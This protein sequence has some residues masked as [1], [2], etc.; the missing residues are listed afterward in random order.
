MHD[1]H[2][3][4][5]TK[6]EWLKGVQSLGLLV[7]TAQGPPTAA[8]ITALFDQIDDD[9]NGFLDLREATAALKT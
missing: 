9:H 4:E 8:S 7:G 6:A 5:L 3:A 1:L 2:M